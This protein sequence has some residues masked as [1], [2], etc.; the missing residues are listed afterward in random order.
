MVDIPPLVDGCIPILILATIVI[1]NDRSR[2]NA[3]TSRGALGK[4]GYSAT[5]FAAASS[6]W[7]LSLKIAAAGFLGSFKQRGFPASSKAAATA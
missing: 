6:R 7:P 5:D 4:S 1:V 2:K 3:H